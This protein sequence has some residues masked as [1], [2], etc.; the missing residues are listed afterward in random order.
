MSR[1]HPKL[2]PGKIYH[3]YNE[4]IGGGTLFRSHQDYQSFLRKS[5]KH[6]SPV[7]EIYGWVLLPGRFDIII[8]VKSEDIIKDH[9]KK[10]KKA[11]PPSLA[12]LCD[13][14]M[15]RVSNWLNSYAKRFN[16]KY[17]RKGG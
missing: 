15:E 14:V 11:E 3:L 2:Q 9:F 12:K 4:A 6:L 16:N 1:F 13:F 8:S 5:R 7:A 17:L 10:M